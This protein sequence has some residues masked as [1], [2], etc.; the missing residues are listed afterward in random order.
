MQHD[1]KML[2]SQT[3]KKEFI[4]QMKNQCHNWKKIFNWYKFVNSWARSQQVYVNFS[5][6][7]FFRYILSF[8][9]SQRN[10]SSQ[11]YNNYWK[12]KTKLS[13]QSVVKSVESK[14]QSQL[15]A[16]KQSLMII[17]EFIIFNQYHYNNQENN[18]FWIKNHYYCAAENWVQIF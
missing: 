7:I 16:F 10:W 17:I 14:F 1:I 4:Q 11:K 18:F 5:Y 9:Q 6:V 8:F 2:T 15:S 12:N 13:D 3:T